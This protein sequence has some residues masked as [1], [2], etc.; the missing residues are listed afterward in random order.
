[1]YI[2]LKYLDLQCRGVIEHLN[3]MYRY[4]FSQNHWLGADVPS[5]I[6]KFVRSNSQSKSETHKSVGTKNKYIKDCQGIAYKRTV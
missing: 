5:E 4:R 3:G 6:R 2:V 1:M